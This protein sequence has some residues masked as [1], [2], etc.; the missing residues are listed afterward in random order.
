M[1]RYYSSGQ[2]NWRGNSN[3]GVVPSGLFGQANPGDGTISGFILYSPSNFVTGSFGA[4]V[5][6]TIPSSGLTAN[7]MRGSAFN[8][9]GMEANP[10]IVTALWAYLDGKGEGERLTESSARAVL[11]AVSRAG[12]DAPARGE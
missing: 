8:I 4:T 12:L 9:G 11:R 7:F 1:L 3:P 10:V 5:P 2:G 6:G